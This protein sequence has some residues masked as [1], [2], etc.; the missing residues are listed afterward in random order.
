MSIIITLQHK[1]TDCNLSFSYDHLSFQYS[2]QFE[3]TRRHQ[4][5]NQSQYQQQ[6]NVF[7]M[8][9]LS[10]DYNF[11]MGQKEEEEEMFLVNPVQL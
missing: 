6:Q 3:F 9:T 2:I 10:N 7:S 1:K 8:F 5:P 11:L 4:N